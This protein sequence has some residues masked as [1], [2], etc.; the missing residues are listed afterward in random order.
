MV[1]L[2]AVSTIIEHHNI[3]A[4]DLTPSLPSASNQYCVEITCD[5]NA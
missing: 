1:S 2:S 5:S 3:S 4:E